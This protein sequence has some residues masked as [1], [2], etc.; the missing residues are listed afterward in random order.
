MIWQI[1]AFIVWAKR[2]RRNVRA[3]TQECRANVLL[4]HANLLSGKNNSRYFEDG[5][6]VGIL[7]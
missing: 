5:R 2:H 3:K 1:K 6:F 7:A 4:R